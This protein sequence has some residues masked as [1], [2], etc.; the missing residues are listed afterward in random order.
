[1]DAIRN[2]AFYLAI[3][4]AAMA[5][6]GFVDAQMGDEQP[7]VE[8][9]RRYNV[10]VIIFTY[11]SSV[12][13]GTEVFVPAKPAT[14][15]ASSIADL[16]SE[17]AV[18][19]DGED[20]SDVVRE[21]G[22]TVA[23][24]EKLSPDEEILGELLETQSL[25]LRLLSDNELTLQDAHERLRRLDAYQPVLW[26]G[27]TQDVHE[28]EMT[29]PIRLRRLGNLPLNIDGEMKLYLGRFLHLVADVSIQ[30]P[31]SGTGTSN[32]S[33]RVRPAR[34]FGR[35]FDYAP[36]RRVEDRAVY[37]RIDD[38]RIMKN[39][40]LRYFDH[41]RF[42]ILAKTT[43]AADAT[44]LSMDGEDNSESESPIGQR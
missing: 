34:S 21:Y 16:D 36:D 29:A 24:P 9:V 20:F 28:E 25:N 13:A 2:A 18:G 15:P 33:Y 3:A 40:D 6:P 27:W 35:D 4:V 5:A 37:Y 26:A 22:D 14:L 11:D 42:G 23:L 44:G 41:P 39:G 31:G 30:A 1:M 19:E 43:R 32:P 8:P 10:E 7:L 12:S 17:T 38:D